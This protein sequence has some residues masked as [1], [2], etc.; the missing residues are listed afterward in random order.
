MSALS[1]QSPSDPRT[2][3]SGGER[4]VEAL[5]WGSQEA[6]VLVLIRLGGTLANEL[7]FLSLYFPMN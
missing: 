6:E 3:A 2:G 4:R 5:D 1:V 7:T